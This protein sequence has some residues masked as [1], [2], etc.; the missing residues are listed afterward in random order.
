MCCIW[1]C[2]RLILVL[3]AK[4][5]L[6]KGPF[7]E[8]PQDSFRD[9]TREQHYPTRKKKKKAMKLCYV[10]ST[11]ILKN[12]T[13]LSLQQRTLHEDIRKTRDKFV[14][15]CRGKSKGSVETALSPVK[16]ITFFYFFPLQFKLKYLIIELK[17]L[18][19]KFLHLW[20]NKQAISS[21]FRVAYLHSTWTLQ[22]KTDQQS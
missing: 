17:C 13:T 2:C 8:R 16:M 21:K 10:T 22:P 14:T 6:L 19:H 12:C 18:K 1:F 3:T 11:C 15:N 4:G 20:E 7:I 9:A 5:A